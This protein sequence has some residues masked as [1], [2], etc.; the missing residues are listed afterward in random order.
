MTGLSGK[1]QRKI[2]FNEMY[3]P[4]FLKDRE[5]YGL[6]AFSMDAPVLYYCIGIQR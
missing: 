4:I 1:D 6:Q 3:V 2:V 5:H